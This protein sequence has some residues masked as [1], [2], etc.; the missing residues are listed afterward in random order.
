MSVTKTVWIETIRH[1]RNNARTDT[2]KDLCDLLLDILNAKSRKQMD[3][4]LDHRAHLL[5]EREP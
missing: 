2:E 5:L 3:A 1:T 4:A